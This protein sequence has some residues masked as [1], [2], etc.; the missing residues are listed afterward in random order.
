MRMARHCV[1]QQLSHLFFS[2]FWRGLRKV[3]EMDAIKDTVGAVRKKKASSKAKGRR[4]AVK[5]QQ[6]A[7]EV[8]D[9]DCRSLV[10]A[11]SSNGKKGEMLSARFLYDLAQKA[12]A[13]GE[14]DGARKFRSMALE[15]AN[16]PEWS[17]KPVLE[18]TRGE[19]DGDGS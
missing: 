4:G 16:S 1:E 3:V 11:L 9:R 14:G 17:G 13:A 5:M 15:I 6:A 10:E 7:D 2:Q 12:E 19:E 8:V 18:E